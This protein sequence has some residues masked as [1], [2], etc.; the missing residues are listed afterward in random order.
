MGKVMFLGVL[1]LLLAPAVFASGGIAITQEEA[2]IDYNEAYA[3][4]FEHISTFKVNNKDL[5]NYANI[6]LTNGSRIDADIF[7][8]SDVTFTIRVENSFGGDGP[9]LR[10]VARVRIEKIDD[11]SDLKEESADFELEPGN[12]NLA[13][14]KIKVPFIAKS[15]AYKTKIEVQGLGA[16]KTL[17]TASTNSVLIVRQLGHDIRITNAVVEPSTLSCGR[18]ST[19]S[20]EITNVG[21]TAE[22]QLALEFKSTALGINS[23]DSGISL[24][25]ANDNTDLPR[26]YKKTF[27]IEVPKFFK[28]G[29]YPITVNLYWQ[30]FILFDQKTIYL[31]VKD[32]S[33]AKQPTT[34]AKNETSPVIVIQPPKI[35]KEIVTSTQEVSILESPVLL[36]MF[37]G[38]FVI[39]ILAVIALAGYAYGYLRKDKV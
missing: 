32:C 6:P 9:T 20:A 12:D 21:S 8:G 10:S 15:G 37:V 11:G 7:P 38:A 39:M 22:N 23:A 2:R 25:S 29:T 35:P 13:D 26:I 1:L 16:N 18:K 30:N 14:I 31:T 28:A 24:V 4:S 34:Q 5:K 33:A 27:G 17:L 3:Y 36:S 19:L